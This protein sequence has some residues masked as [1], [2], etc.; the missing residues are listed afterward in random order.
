MKLSHSESVKLQHAIEVAIEAHRDQKRS[1]GT[2]YICHPMRVMESVKGFGY[3]T[4]CAAV[5]H[6]VIEDSS[7]FTLEDMRAAFGPNIADAVKILT[8]DDRP[9]DQY[10]IKISTN[11]IAKR[12]KIADLKDNLNL[13]E[14]AKFREHEAKRVHKYLI[15]LKTLEQ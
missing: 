10:I 8:K 14:L 6:D 3:E 15:A 13:I 9:Y 12:V 5:L 2:P 1:N 11:K 4:M 7:S